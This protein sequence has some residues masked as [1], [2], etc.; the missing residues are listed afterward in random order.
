MDWTIIAATILFATKLASPSTAPEI[1][2]HLPA[3]LRLSLQEPGA[4]QIRANVSAIPDAVGSAFAKA[5]REERFTM[6]EPRAAWQ[7]TDV[8]QR[9]ALPRRRL[10]KVALSR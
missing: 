4:F 1:V 9:P 8:V 3:D 6:A 5:T 10:G 7:A 2:R